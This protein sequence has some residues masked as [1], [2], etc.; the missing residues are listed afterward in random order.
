MLVLPGSIGILPKSDVKSDV[1]LR[2]Q[3]LAGRGKSGSSRSIAITSP[4]PLPLLPHHLLRHPRHHQP[5][6]E[7]HRQ[8]LILDRQTPDFLEQVLVCS[9]QWISRFLVV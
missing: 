8:Q 6:P 4:Q 1:G 7:L 5:P 9:D 3:G 2:W